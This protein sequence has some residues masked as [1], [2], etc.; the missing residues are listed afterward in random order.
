LVAALLC[1]TAC[2]DGTGDAP[3]AGALAATLPTPT[4]PPAA[5]VAPTTLVASATSVASSVVPG[6]APPPIGSEPPATSPEQYPP[7]TSAPSPFCPN[8]ETGVHEYTLSGGGADHPHRVFIPSAYG[9][10]KLPA[11]IDFHGLGSNGVEQATFSGYEQLAEA[12]GFIVVHP[13]GVSDADGGPSSW[14]LVGGQGAAERDDVRFAHAVVDDLI[15]NWCADPNRIYVTGMSN[16][17]F[18]TARLL[19]E[20]PERIAA[21][22]SVAGLYHPPGCDPARSVPYQGIHGTADAVVPYDGN[23][24]STLLTPDSPATWR[25]FFEQVIPDEFAEFAADAGCDPEAA[26]T[27][28]GEDVVRHDYAGCATPMTFFEVIG[29]GHTWPGS[30]LA[31][32]TERALGHSTDS[33]DATADGWAFMSLQSL[34]P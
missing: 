20:M 22:V 29:G 34:A 13:T 19:C 14:Q 7:P 8:V 32:L 16:G 11:V 25:V 15:S 26:A 4:T 17:G 24:R 5:A 21:A 18:F 10:D 3:D 1:A 30:P 33:I 2:T 6:T 28:V 27:N 9:T 23:G 31:A 12:E